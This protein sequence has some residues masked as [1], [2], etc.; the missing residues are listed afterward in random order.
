MSSAEIAEYTSVHRTIDESPRDE[1]A[2]DL[3]PRQLTDL[4]PIAEHYKVSESASSLASSV[5]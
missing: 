4:I 5:A 1:I 2:Y 3:E